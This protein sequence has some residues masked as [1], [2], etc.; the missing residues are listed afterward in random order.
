MHKT[1]GFW[2][3]ISS[4]AFASSLRK[5]EVHGHRGARARFPENSLAA[6]QYALEVGVDVLEL[7]LGVSRDGVLVV[8]HDPMINPEHCLNPD[9]SA[10]TQPLP[11]HSL[12]LNVIQGFDCGSLPHKDFPEQKRI[13]G[14]HIPT[15]DEVFD[16]VQNSALPSAAHVEFNIETKSFPLHP[17]WAPAPEAFAKLVIQKLKARGMTSRSLLQSFDYRTLRAARKLEPSL[18]LSA[19]VQDPLPGPVSIGLALRPNV[20]SPHW[21]LIGFSQIRRLHQ[22]GIRVVPWTAN[23]PEL[24]STLIQNNVDGIITDD[25]EPLIQFLKTKGSK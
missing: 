7:D 6:F 25:P 23:T 3:L 12:P 1:L 21:K 13:P 11:M 22:K 19:L 10:L 4:G 24:W 2:L 18:R 15:L 20:V 14:S 17:E 8:N 5:I 9:G 16:L